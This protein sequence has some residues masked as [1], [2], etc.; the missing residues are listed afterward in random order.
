M[1]SLQKLLGKE[2]KFFRE[3]RN[4]GDFEKLFTV[5]RWNVPPPH[6]FIPQWRK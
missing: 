2:D 4:Q 6:S 1:F 5:Q 3:L